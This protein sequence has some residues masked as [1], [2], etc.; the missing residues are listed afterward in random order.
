MFHNDANLYGHEYSSKA[1][2]T[3]SKSSSV[4]LIV[5][6]LEDDTGIGLQLSPKCL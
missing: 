3:L 1:S 4:N 2:F 6:H 5:E